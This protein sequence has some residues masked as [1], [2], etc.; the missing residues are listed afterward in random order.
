MP[1]DLTYMW[2]LM[3]K[4]KTEHEYME[5]TDR[6]QWEEGSGDWVKEGEGMSQRTYM[7]NDPQTQTVVWGWPQEGAAGPG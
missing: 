4:T 2:S 5:Q 1:Y 7:H 6:S 3:N